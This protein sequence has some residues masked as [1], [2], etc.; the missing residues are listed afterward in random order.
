[1]KAD[2]E[3]LINHLIETYSMIHRN[4][5]I[6]IFDLDLNIRYASDRLVQML[7]YQESETSTSVLSHSLLGECVINILT[8]IKN[9]P[10]NAIEVFEVNTKRQDQFILLYYIFT[11]LYNKE[12]HDQVIGIEVRTMVPTYPFLFANKGQLFEKKSNIALQKVYKLTPRQHEIV[13]LYFHCKSASEIA[14]RLTKIHKKNVSSNTISS[15]TNRLYKKFNVY[16]LSAMLN[17]AY[18]CDYHKNIPRSLLRDMCI[19][20]Q[21]L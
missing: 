18:Q 15:I 14:R 8:G 20:V 9:S 17:K 2:A 16:N 11:P 6:A 3:I 10:D 7:I 19:A 21:D 13:F 5:G 12:I 1:M 4:D